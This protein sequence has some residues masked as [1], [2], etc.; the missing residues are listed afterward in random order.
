M[1]LALLE[2]LLFTQSAPVSIQQVAHWLSLDENAVEAGLQ[3]L[4]ERLEVR[5]SGLALDWVDG[6]VRLTTHPRLYASLQD[7]LANPD[8]EPLSHASWEV[9]AI[10]A[11]RQ[12]ITRLEIESIRQTGSERAIETLVNRDLI[13][14]VGRKEAPGRPILY[15]T[16][17]GF[18]QQFGLS[19][20]DALP[21]LSQLTEPMA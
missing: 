18:L 4:A 12:P 1:N 16:T 19:S 11:Y 5:E 7:R 8:P 21:Q 10:V 14:E 17:R 9:L 13:E 6:G 3:A 2:A 15:G 20:L